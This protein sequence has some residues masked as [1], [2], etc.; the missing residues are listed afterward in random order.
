MHAGPPK[1]TTAPVSAPWSVEDLELHDRPEPPR[2]RRTSDLLRLILV[3]SVTAL[4]VVLGS[5]G[6]GTTT[7][8]QEDIATAVSTVPPLVVSLLSA[9]NNLIV[10]A[11]PV[12]LVIDLALRRRLRLFLTAV[13][14]ASLALLA[15]EVFVAVANDLLDG[16]LQDALT[17]PVGG[18]SG[19]T[20][21][22]F[23][24]FAAV[25]ALM[26][27]QGQGVRPRSLAI[28]WATLGGL[29]VLLLIDRRATPLA[30]AIS[31]LG[32]HVIGLLVRYVAGTENPRA[33][34][35]AI[36]AALA[37]VGIAPAWMSQRDVESPTGRRFDL[38]TVDGRHGVVQVF[39]PDRRT[40]QLLRQLTRVVRVRTWVTRYPG[41]TEKAQLQQSVVPIMMARSAGVRT[42]GVLGAVEVDDQTVAFAEEREPGLR[43]LSE[44]SPSAISDEA[45]AQMWREM[46]RM[47]HAGVAHEGLHPGSFAV[48][49]DGR[50][51]ILGLAQGEIA[52]PRLRMRLDRAELLIASAVLVGTDRAITAA[53]RAVGAEDLANLP[54]L[55]QPVALNAATR[56]ALKEHPGLLDRL[57]DEAIAR[58]PEPSA[59]EVRLERLRPRSVVSL[60]AATFAVYVLAGQLSNV[61]F[62]TVFSRIDWVWAV[63]AVLA[64]LV[65]Y[66]GSAW[67]IS[68][69]SPVAIS[70]GRWLMAQFAATFVTLVAPAAVG[71]A[72]TNVRVIQQAG[73]APGLAIAS[74]GVSTGVS[75][76]TTVLALIVVTVFSADDPNWNIEVPSEGV[77]IGVGVVLALMVLAFAVPMSRRIIVARLRPTWENAGPRLL[78]V[79]RNP[80]RLAAGVGGSLLTSLAYAAT[81][82]AAVKAYGADIPFGA[83]VV[84]YLGAGILGSVAPTPGGIGAV[85]A[86]LIAGLS[87]VGVP[88][89]AALPAALLYRTVTFWLPTI[90]GWMAFQ[91][92][93]RRNAI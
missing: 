77:L 84:V 10:V 39:D 26:T 38:R 64:S 12:Y 30:I 8:L 14:A 66:L 36:A 54:G 33:S 35:R 69:F 34:A 85:E 59:D 91:W 15:V 19:R 1:P 81:L 28:S 22:A 53:E 93:Q 56:R 25:P 45:L 3:L 76:V 9:L 78:D 63:V 70:L 37:R 90:P 43:L 44:L 16:A 13:L 57:R 68:P 48:D 47:H 88:A 32:G 65:T 86:A 60:V 62:G 18:N 92:L 46:R 6:S 74:V 51:W 20:L 4:L 11:L 82:F 71:S 31:V 24:L 83:A 42:P 27:V 50:V 52:A 72:G 79:L 58:A 55:M 5:L 40:G 89:D 49:H 75:F 41:L 87:A 67:T 21:P 29:A 61:N 80:R 73:A 2:T 23:G 17:L 7:G